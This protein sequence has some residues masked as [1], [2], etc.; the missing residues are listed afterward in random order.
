M[1]DKEDWDIVI[2]HNSNVFDLRLSEVWK[3]RYLIA[4]FVKRDFISVYK[5]TILGPLWFVLQPI[6]T[7]ATYLLIFNN[8]AQ[9]STDGIP[10]ILFYMSGV[11]FWNYFSVSFL[12]TADTFITNAGVFGKVYFPRLTV[13]IATILSS[14]ISFGIQLVFFMAV[15]AY[16]LLSDK[17]HFVIDYSS[18]ILLP[19]IILLM[20][21]LSM[22]MGTIISA[23]TTKYRDLRFLITFGI[24]LLMY[25][26][27]VVYP[28]SMVSNAKIKFLLYL[29]PMTSIIET[30]RYIVLGA[31][32]YSI[33]A[34]SY[35]AIATCFI[36][37]IG[38]SVF[39]KVEKNF[40][41]TI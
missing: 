4:M 30:F 29:N 33:Q 39:N 15:Y 19:F 25:A 14:F 27:P 32:D 16:Y 38:I 24:Q 41:D 3:Y 21:V 36:A 8:I 31:G 12:K 34:L 2:E 13:P 18:L 17:L 9:L 22:G 28:M 40:M 37:V 1:K 20:A 26:T 23:M 35:S 10:P 7:T 6:L 11:L 5:Q